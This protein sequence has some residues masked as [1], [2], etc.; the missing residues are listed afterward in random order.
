MATK[1]RP[2]KKK[3]AAKRVA[4]KQ[5][6]EFWTARFTFDTVAWLIIG[7]M[8]VAIAVWTYK[9][10]SQ[11]NEIYDQIQANNASSD[12]VTPVSHKKHSKT[13]ATE[14]TKK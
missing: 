13:P 1:K 5:Q 9:T 11:V 4:K 8:V 10:N 3:T 6:S 14:T 2:A 7:V 12:I